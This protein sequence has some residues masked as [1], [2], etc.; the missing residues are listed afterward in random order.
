MEVH[1]V[2]YKTEYKSPKQALRYP[3]GLAVVGFLFQVKINM[4]SS[5]NVV[6]LVSWL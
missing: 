3:D 4:Y 5:L 2:H 6:F 1:A